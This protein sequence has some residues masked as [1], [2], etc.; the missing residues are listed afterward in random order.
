MNLKCNSETSA[1]HIHHSDKETKFPTLRSSV[2]I[3]VLHIVRCR[4]H[5]TGMGK[6]L[7]LHHCQCLLEK[8]ALMTL[9][10]RSVWWIMHRCLN[11]PRYSLSWVP[12][13][14]EGLAAY[15]SR[16]VGTSLRLQLTPST[17][18]LWS[19]SAGVRGFRWLML[20]FAERSGPTC[21]TNLLP[22]MNC[23][24]HFLSSVTRK[25]DFVHKSL[26]RDTEYFM[27]LTRPSSGHH[28]VPV[29][30]GTYLDVA[31]ASLR[32][33]TVRAPLSR[34]RLKT[35]TKPSLLNVVF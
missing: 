16:S 12:C 1:L 4:F 10:L 15:G 13:S 24:W 32:T 19:N 35:K 27:C 34:D 18:Q 25:Q 30:S 28:I 29:F 21:L 17:C 2:E 3:A 7:T 8:R 31:S 33:P 22:Y 9:F 11:E 6:A 26:L 14:G 5:T 23:R 20:V